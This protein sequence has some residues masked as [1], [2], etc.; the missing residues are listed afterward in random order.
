MNCFIK[1]NSSELLGAGHFV[2]CLNLGYELRR[3]NVSVQYVYNTLL[4]P[5]KEILI[6]DNFKFQEIFL[7][8]K[9]SLGDS[10]SIQSFASSLGIN[11]IDWIVIDDYD[12]DQIWDVDALTICDKLLVIEDTHKSHRICNLLL[13]MN[14]RTKSFTAELREKYKKTEILIGPKFALLDSS[15]GGMEIAKNMQIS[16]I[17]HRVFVY[18]GSHDDYSL[19]LQTLQTLS[20]KFPG[21]KA[22]IVIQST[23]STLSEVVE[24]VA[25]N[26]EHFELFIDPVSLREI[27]TSCTISIGAG[28]ISLWERISLGLYCITVA[29]AENQIVPLRELQHDD[30][31]VYLGIAE[32]YTG[33]KL[34]ETFSYIISHHEEYKRF[35][36]ICHTISD[37]LGCERVV[38]IMKRA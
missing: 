34:S 38:E 29:T 19:T 11:V 15:Y 4:D 13:D 9:K 16:K 18:F 28:G 31:I 17:V 27:M 1:T 23:N 37:G 5:H 25:K 3:N 35:R 7:S 24:L 32:L 8:D 21:T 20:D 36:E 14:Y 10:K 30:L 22:R 2:R 33:E 26:P 6:R 12:S